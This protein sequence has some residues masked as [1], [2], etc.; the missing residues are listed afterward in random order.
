MENRTVMRLALIVVDHVEVV[1]LI[2]HAFDEMTVIELHA[3]MEHVVVS[4]TVV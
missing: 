4:E 3:K 2:Q 1:Q